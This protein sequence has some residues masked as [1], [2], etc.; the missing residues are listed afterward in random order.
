MSRFTGRQHKG[1]VR[2]AREQRR[3]D[4]VDRQKEYDKTHKPV[5]EPVAPEAETPVE[6]R[7]K[8]LEER[9]RKQ[10]TRNRR[11]NERRS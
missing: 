5:P 8:T 11:K 1:A 3:L 6:A 2:E 10:R 7:D 4:A 9:K